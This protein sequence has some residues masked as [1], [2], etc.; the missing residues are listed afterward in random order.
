MLSLFGAAVSFVGPRETIGEVAVGPEDRR[1]AC[2]ALA[3]E[4]GAPVTTL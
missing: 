3:I 4:V 1:R 2:S